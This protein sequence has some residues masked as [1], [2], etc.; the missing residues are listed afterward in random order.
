MPP[1]RALPPDEPEVPVSSLLQELLTSALVLIEDWELLPVPVRE[2]LAR[3]PDR[4]TLL[5]GLV[6]HKLLTEYQAS[7]VR[8]GKTHGL[9]LGNYRLLDRLGAGGM[10]VVFRA[11]HVR[12]RRQVA[13]KVLS[14]S[15]VETGQ[16][17]RRFYGEM[18]AVAQLQHP[19][20]VAAMDAGEVSGIDADAPQI[21]YFVME[22]VAGQ[23]LEEHVLAH[24]PL[25]PARACDLV[26]QVASALSE[27]HKHHLV[28]RDIKPSNILLTP[29]GQAKLLDF[30][31]ARRF[32]QRMTEPGTV[33][34]SIDYMAPEQARDSTNVD[35]R[36]DLYALGGTLFWCLTGRSPFVTQG[37]MI[38][39]LVR[40]L[41]EP[42]PS[43]R[44]VAPQ[45]PAELD[46]VIARMMANDAEERYPTPQAVMN[47]LIP[48]LQPEARDRLM[49]PPQPARGEGQAPWPG[50]PEG[51]GR[52]NHVL[53]VDDEPEVRRLC[54]FALEAEGLRC[55]E[56]GNG[57]Q[58]LAAVHDNPSDLVLLD[59]AMPGMSGVDVCRKLRQNPPSPH[60]KV[61][62]VSA[63]AS[64]D[65]MALMLSSGAD[66]YLTKPFSLV[67]LSARVQAALRLKEAQDRSDQ[68]TRHLLTAN[69]QLEQNLSARDSDL[70]HA[71][72]ALVLALA[73]LV[74]CRDTE[75][76]GHLARLQHYCRALAEEAAQLPTFANQIEPHFVQLLECCAPLHDIGKVGLPDHVLLKPGKLTA[77]ERVLM[78]A[79]TLIGS[80][81]LKQVARQ[82]GSALAFLQTAIDVVRHHHERFDGKGYPDRLAGSGIPLAARIVAVADVYDALRSR[83]PY[84]PALSHS[85]AVQIILEGSPGQFD[86]ALLEAFQRCHQQFEQIFREL[87]P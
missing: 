57:A 16:T 15:R 21:H 42:P 48:F 41:I 1:S 27:A 33:L 86:P 32:H 55:D 51:L 80:D 81:T 60:L 6:E 8:S 38:E 26:Y 43:I 73:K 71:R 78:Q 40:R 77:E 84:K 18:R 58:A 28:H 10:G 50:E 34:G 11:E 52:V 29:E 53:L 54:R 2:E 46:A 61:I 82:H 68:L 85:A 25:P 49:G 64:A 69:Q 76:G 66:D 22:Y 44:A 35:I 45:L 24:G 12:M 37:N 65:E 20:I 7:R 59:I 36:A 74:E 62:M 79:H 56:A 14:L 13:I 83:R 75:T 3:A 87:S 5:A 23:N 70:V 47:A 4:D 39:E 72:N 67:Q 9:V 17:L 19:N 63:H 30:G 31:V